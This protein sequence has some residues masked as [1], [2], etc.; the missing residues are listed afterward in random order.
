MIQ[1]T[2]KDRLQ[3][4]ASWHADEKVNRSQAKLLANDARLKHGQLVSEAM[5]R[6]L[7]RRPERE[8]VKRMLNE[9]HEPETGIIWICWGEAVLAIKTNATSHVK[10]CRY[11]LTWFF[12]SLVN[13]KAGRFRNVVGRN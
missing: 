6:F 10:D 9:R 1:F 3:S 8:E 4:F 7:G 13:P 11:Y 2:L 12:K 5:E